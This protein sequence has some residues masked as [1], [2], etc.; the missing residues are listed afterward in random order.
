MSDVLEDA[1]GAAFDAIEAGAKVVVIEV[2]P[3]VRMTMLES[4]YN[5]DEEGRSVRAEITRRSMSNEGVLF[6]VQVDPT[7]PE[8]GWRVVTS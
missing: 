2:T 4:E 6:T 5:D 3:A 8:P 1:A 7:V